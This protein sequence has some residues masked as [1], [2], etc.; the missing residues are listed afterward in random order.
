MKVKAGRDEEF[1]KIVHL[2]SNRVP[3]ECE[4]CIN[5]IWLRDSDDPSRFALLEQWSSRVAVL[6]YLDWLKVIL[7]PPRKGRFD[8]LEY[9][10]IKHHD[11]VK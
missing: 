1:E 8:L 5:Y 9:L 7:G 4:G 11:V 3:I 6:A 10:E 2:L